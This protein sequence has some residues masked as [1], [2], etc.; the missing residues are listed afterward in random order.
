MQ[1]FEENIISIYG[2]KGQQWLQDMPEITSKIALEYKLRDLKPVD[3]M[4]FN[5]VAQAYQDD[6]PVILKLGLNDK[7]ISKEAACL[8]A[9]ANCGA[10][11][12]IAN[13]NSMILMQRAVPGITLKEYFPDQDDMAT[14][15]FCEIVTSL[16]T[17]KM[18]INHNFYN[19]RDLL[20]TLDQ[21][22]AIPANV[23]TRARDLKDYLLTSTTNEVL[24]HGD[25]HH[26]NILSN[27][28]EWLVIDPK[29]FIGDPVFEVAAFL[30][31]PSPELLT[32]NNPVDLVKK[33]VKI[34]QDSLGYDEQRI[35]DW[36]YVKSVLCWA[37]C[38]EDNLE[39]DYFRDFIEMVD[40]L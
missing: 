12:V 35:K 25:L 4:T 40:Q 30:C 8:K 10:V 28:D 32:G 31:N 17:A 39:G 3:N 34:C 23:L 19:V 6:K 14:N 15:I 21:E 37:W 18:Q 38:L 16:H 13:T 36:L 2:D 24:L 7:A 26:D 5:Y 20:K 33:R 27:D 22:I 11:D 29:G 9:F 1:T